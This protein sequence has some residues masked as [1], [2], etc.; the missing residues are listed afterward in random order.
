[1]AN[2]H[3]GEVDICLDG[4]IYPLCL[5]LGALAE[6]EDRLMLDNIGELAGRFAGGKVRSRDLM[7]ILGTALRAGGADISDEAAASMQCEGGAMG[8]TRTLVSLIS[9]TFS[10]PSDNGGEETSANP[11]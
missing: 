5:T 11:I 1:M 7:I 2:R 9:L 10:P 3:R 6:L 8:L 4:K